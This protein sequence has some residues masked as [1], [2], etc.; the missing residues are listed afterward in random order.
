MTHGEELFHKNYKDK[1]LIIKYCIQY[2][3]FPFLNIED[4]KYYL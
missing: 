3:I 4:I 1:T 2:V